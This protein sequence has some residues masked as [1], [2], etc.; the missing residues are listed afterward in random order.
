VLCCVCSTFVIDAK[1]R[2]T[3]TVLRLVCCLDLGLFVIFDFK[4][5]AMALRT[6]TRLTELNLLGQPSAFGDSCLEEFVA[7]FSY[8]VTLTKIIW[9]LDSRKSFAI[10]KLLVRNNTIIKWLSESKDV[11]SLVPASCNIPELAQ[12]A[13]N[14]VRLFCVRNNGFCF[15]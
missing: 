9:R 7:L 15:N 6:N 8:N 4:A 1:Y 10:N 13:A 11:S 14:E 12:V 2:S 5:I 3:T